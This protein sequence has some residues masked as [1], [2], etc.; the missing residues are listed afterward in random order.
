MA[1]L[2][3]NGSRGLSWCCVVALSLLTA[4]G[5]DD[6][7]ADTGSDT[8]PD[9]GSDAGADAVADASADAGDSLL[10]TPEFTA[11]PLEELPVVFSGYCLIDF[12]CEAGNHCFGGRCASECDADTPCGGGI[13]CSERGRCLSDRK[14]ADAVPPV[15]GL[16]LTDGP[17]SE[18]AVGPNDD[19][20]LLGVEVASVDGDTLP[21]RLRY[22][23]EDSEGITDGRRVR[24]A[25]V[26]NG[27][28]TIEVPINRTQV[29]ESRY[30]AV[31]V[32]VSTEAGSFTTTLVPAPGAAASYGG[33]VRMRQFG[34]VAL[35]I[36]FQVVTQP[37]EASLADAEK[38]WLLLET[39][40][41][42]MFSPVPDLEGEYVARELTFDALLQ[43]WVATTRFDYPLDEGSFLASAAGV[44]PQRQLRF[45]LELDSAGALFGTLSDRWTGLYDERTSGGTTRSGVVVFTGDVETARVGDVTLS[46]A[47]AEELDVQDDVSSSPLQPLP[48]L[49]ACAEETFLGEGGG[50]VAF[51][52]ESGVTYSCADGA[53]DALD[54]FLSADD[55][56]RASCALALAETALAG[57]TTAALLRDFFDDDGSTPGGQSFDA[58]MSDCAAGVDG[59]CRPTP[60]VLCARALVARTFVEP[61]EEIAAASVLVDAF[62]RLSR[63]AFLGRQLGAFRTDADLRLEWLELNNLP[64]FVTSALR[65]FIAGQLDIW[66]RTVLDVQ[67]EVVAGQYSPEALALL[68]RQVTETEAVEQRKQLLFEMS[69]TWRA[70]MD[71]LIVA[72]QRWNAL[73]IGTADRAEDLAF[74]STRSLD[75]YVLA[76][77]AGNLNLSAGAGFANATFGGGFGALLR[78]QRKL[79]LPF[80]ALV[81]ARDAEV[82]V[83]RSLDATE[84]NYTLLD[85]LEE[86]AT[87]EIRKAATAVSEILRETSER[88]LSATLVRNQLSNEMDELAQRVVELCGRPADCTVS[89]VASGAPGCVVRVD[90]GAC[91]FTFDENGEVVGVSSSTAASSFLSINEAVQGVVLVQQEYAN[92][93]ARAARL[94]SVA[95][96]FA[97]TIERWNAERLEAVGRV[98]QI[99]ADAEEQAEGDLAAVLANISQQ[100]AL[101]GQ[102][103]AD[104]QADAQVWNAVRTGGVSSDFATLRAAFGMRRSA[105]TV[106][107]AARTAG[108]GFVAAAAF[109]PQVAG[110]SVF[111]P[112]FA[113]RGALMVKATVAAAIGEGVAIGL[114]TGAEELRIQVDQARALR[115]AELTNLREQDIADDLVV[116]NQIDALR[117]E[118][119]VA[120]TEA[121]VREFQLDRLIAA[122]E[123]RTEAELAY[124]RDRIELNDRITEAFNATMEVVDLGVRIQQAQLQVQQRVLEHARDVQSAGLAY[125]RLEDLQNQFQ[126][127]ESLLGS[128]A[129]VF[130]WANSLA[131]AEARLERAK[132]TLMD[133]LVAMEYY[134][135]RP[136]MDQRV[137]ILL[138]R[139]TFQLETIASEMATLQDVCGAGQP[140][141]AS[142][143]ISLRRY[144]DADVARVNDST[145]ERYA[146]SDLFYASLERGEVSVDRRVRLGSDVSGIDLGSR[147][148]LLSATFTFDVDEFANLAASCDARI[149]SFDVELVGEGLGDGLP[150]VTVVYDGESRLRSCQPDL[151]DYVNSLDPEATSFNDVTV[152]RSESRA[153]SLIAGVNSFPSA[154]AEELASRTLNGL[155]LAST[156]TLIIDPR[157]GDNPDFDWSRLED[158]R[159]RVRYGY[160]DFFPRGECL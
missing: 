97:E 109:L 23:V 39:G 53:I 58:F 156:Y 85:D 45:E 2:T 138:A 106:D 46:A 142:V 139:N 115:Q 143:D 70:A 1:S 116:Q 35:P 60:R 6:A 135:V 153:F 14:D 87:T 98:D 130:A 147:D 78:V 108:A 122:L 30:N 73:H 134:A 119:E 4:C 131:R 11:L 84:T 66:R 16:L 71:A 120:L 158:V 110:A 24:N 22:V 112:S 132:V 82:V 72:A 144:I 26:L 137:Q 101:R 64:S 3:L 9:T 7:G 65:D 49:N 114:R 54:S 81:Y 92:A 91:G 94:E 69:Q 90:A 63:E 10:A 38:A 117:A 155:P 75:L 41:E 140:N 107:F 145:G 21:E 51:E 5:G 61:D 33:T 160:Q 96:S 62:G 31:E 148:D 27:T 113:E 20:V 129:I 105:E 154:S 52:T 103:A 124:A 80:S 40:S 36:A 126:N 50:P 159:L 136:F 42:S 59:L 151:V 111:D 93:E 37:E 127:V 8:G 123:A 77:A 79:A 146:S 86:D 133:W 48:G 68:S 47:D 28:A 34:S 100:N 76:G 121:Q 104:A 141:R 128:P 125:A 12:D 29:D 56:S 25:P 152:F 17:T 13:S 118:A 89:D 99:I 88:E 83:S 44:V 57:N 157:A 15:A 43:R 149:E 74:V 95:E 67:M 32:R 150:A 55:A 102:L 19:V 18:S